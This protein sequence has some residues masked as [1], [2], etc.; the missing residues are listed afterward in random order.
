MPT[1]IFSLKQQVLAVEAGAWSTQKTP[2][3]DYLVVAG[4]G[5]GGGAYGTGGGAGGMLAG[6]V[7]VTPGSAVTVTIGG[8]GSSSA[9]GAASVFGNISAAGG[10]F[11]VGGWG[12]RAGSGGSG[13]GS[14]GNYL[15]N[16]FGI[17][18][19]GQG[20]NGGN[21]YDGTGPAQAGGGGAGTVGGDG[22]GESPAGFGGN[23]LGTYI[24]GALAVYAGGGGGGVYNNS[25][26]NINGLGGTG[27]G[28]NGGTPGTNNGSPGTA[29]TGG[30][31]GGASVLAGGSTTGGNGGSGIVI[32]SY[33]D[34]Y[35]AP[36]STTGSPTVSTSGTGSINLTSSQRIVYANNAAFQFGTGSFTVEAFAYLGT[37]ASYNIIAKCADDSS[38]GN[39]WTLVFASGVPQFWVNGSLALAGSAVATSTWHHIAVVRNGTA[40]VL[41]VNGVSVSTATS[42]TNIAPTQPL[43]VGGEQ[44][45]GSFLL[46]GDVS[47]LRVV[48]GS[49][50]YTAAFPS[51]TVPLTSVSGTSLLLG[52]ASGA[53]LADSSGNNF[54][55]TSVVNSPTW[56][57]LSPFATGLGYKNRVYTWTSSGSITF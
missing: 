40:L 54:V 2:F 3:V 4:G 14:G 21:A 19:V 35:A 39:G 1:G 57:S 44:G 45:T 42:S 48:K 46:G 32:I 27:G 17:G 47:N 30:G 31:G 34:T 12:T 28:G 52:A 55:P 16:A 13:G 36:V 56:N 41:Y 18:I 53:F 23:G 43:S 7:F 11:G 29:N 10:G 20:N 38:W 33:P 49:A 37:F 51:P 26:A 9:N 15:S 25:T 24:G 8:G 50:V 5:G 6:S 22:Y